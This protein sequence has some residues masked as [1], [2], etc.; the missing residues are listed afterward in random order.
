MLTEK[1]RSY[2]AEPI[3]LLQEVHVYEGQVV[4]KILQRKYY[5]P[6]STARTL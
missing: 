3:K 1:A 5:I 2:V 6:Q 4:V